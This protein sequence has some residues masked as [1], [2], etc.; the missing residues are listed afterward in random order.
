MNA[1][2]HSFTVEFWGNLHSKCGKITVFVSPPRS[3]RIQLLHQL[4]A[5]IDSLIPSQRPRISSRYPTSLQARDSK[6]QRG[7]HQPGC[8]RRNVQ[9]Y[10]LHTIR[11]GVGLCFRLRIQ[12]VPAQLQTISRDDKQPVLR[13]NYP[14]SACLALYTPGNVDST[15]L[16]YNVR[17]STCES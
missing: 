5:S 12:G 7:V 13:M 2:E 15:L 3:H 4:T 17:L 10:I 14:K 16:H 8:P 9:L 1:L 11:F 6:S